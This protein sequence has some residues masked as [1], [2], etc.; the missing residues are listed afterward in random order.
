M[1]HNLHIETYKLLKK[2][3]KKTLHIFYNLFIMEMQGYSVTK[4][5]SPSL[6]LVYP[7]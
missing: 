6:N 3:K 5:I 2:Q 7:I 4:K 1:C